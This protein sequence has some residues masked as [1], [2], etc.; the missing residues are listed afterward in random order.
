VVAVK[1]LLI[2]M[3]LVVSL[4]AGAFSIDL[5][6]PQAATSIEVLRTP[7]V[8]DDGGGGGYPCVNGIRYAWAPGFGY[9]P[10]GYC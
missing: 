3:A 4:F 5:T 1:R 7:V 2:I 9:V 6:A 10:I 8:V